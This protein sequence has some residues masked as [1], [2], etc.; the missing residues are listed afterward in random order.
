V[1]R[2]F[3]AAPNSL[4]RSGPSACRWSGCPPRR[5]PQKPLRA[6]GA[7]TQC[8]A[9]RSPEG[10]TASTGEA[11]R[12]SSPR[13]S[14]AP[15]EDRIGSVRHRLARRAASVAGTAPR[16]R[17]NSSKLISPTPPVT[18]PGANPSATGSGVCRSTTREVGPQGS[19]VQVAV[20]VVPQ[21]GQQLP[22]PGRWST[23]Q[24]P[25]MCSFSSPGVWVRL[26]RPGTASGR[27]AP[28]CAT[29]GRRPGRSSPPGSPA[30][31][32]C[33]SSAPAV[34]SSP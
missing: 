2:S 23:H 29:G 12:E 20:A 19:V 18:G 14:L 6:G 9:A 8:R 25:F 16:R 7:V 26:I 11:A 21:F 27:T 28:A 17:L 15:T 34:A 5:A 1:S 22:G 10:V 4:P 32:A 30:P 33:P 13:P 31:S 24:G 3:R